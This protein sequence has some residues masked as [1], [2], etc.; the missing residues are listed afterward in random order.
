MEKRFDKEI[1]K[2]MILYISERCDGNPTFGST[3]LNKILHYSDFLWYGFTGESISNETYVRQEHGQVPKH[4]LQVRKELEDE[5]NLRIEERDY[6]GKSQKRPVVTTSIKYH[7][8]TSDQQKFIDQV[9]DALS[10]L[11]A[12]EVSEQI[13]HQDL[14]W[15]YLKNGEEIPYE[16][17]FF[18]RKNPIPD[19]TMN[20]A[21][22]VVNEYEESLGSGSIAI[23]DR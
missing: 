14:S 22:R 9:I 15:Q 8:L 20:W 6:F 23:Q 1:F 7:K 2:E 12:T 3:H 18:R 16:T 5:G 17:V 13:A 19:E 10:G 21:K 4:L 11:S